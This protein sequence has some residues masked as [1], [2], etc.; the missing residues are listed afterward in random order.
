MS[1]S[2][3]VVSKNDSGPRELS[4]R[5]RE[6]IRDWQNSPNNLVDVDVCYWA[7]FDEEE[8]MLI[9]QALE[10]YAPFLN[11]HFSFCIFIIFFGSR[12][13]LMPSN[14]LAYKE[15]HL[16]K[17]RQ[18]IESG[19]I[20]PT[21]YMHHLISD[22]KIIGADK[23]FESVGPAVSWMT[24]QTYFGPKHYL[25]KESDTAFKITLD[26]DSIALYFESLAFLKDSC[27]MVYSPDLHTAMPSC[28]LKVGQKSLHMTPNV[29]FGYEFYSYPCPF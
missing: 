3:A 9:L 12:D 4:D 10:R 14:T 1:G 11:I 5:A 17:L 24:S 23:E 28:K 26:F 29:L 25:T 19:S 16:S 13:L 18:A 7:S 21:V 22:S 15:V 6:F 8:Q 2:D 20:K 27:E